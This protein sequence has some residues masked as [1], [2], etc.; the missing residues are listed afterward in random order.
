MCVF[1]LACL[2]YASLQ[3]NPVLLKSLILVG[4]GV[5]IRKLS[6]YDHQETPEASPSQPDCRITGGRR[7]FEWPIRQ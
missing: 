5:D 1:M 2:V 4:R 7:S 6:R 3:D